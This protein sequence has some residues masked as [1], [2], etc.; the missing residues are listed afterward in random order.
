[1]E[2]NNKTDLKVKHLELVQKVVERMAGNSAMCKTA[3]LTLITGLLAFSGA[4][5]QNFLLLSALPVSILFGALDAYYLNL[6]RGFRSFYNKIR[7]EP[8][9]L[10]NFMEINSIKEPFFKTVRRPIIFWFYLGII[11][12]LLVLIMLSFML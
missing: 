7:V 1:M 4:L 2:E 12:I 11:F 3:C 9:D 8:L 6:E 5:E 10:N